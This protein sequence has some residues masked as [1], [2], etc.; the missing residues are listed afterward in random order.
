[1]FG[2]DVEHDSE[3]IMQDTHWASGYFGYFPSYA[4]GNI[5]NA[6]QF[7][8]LKKA[9]P[10]YK[11]VIRSGDLSPIRAWLK[12]QIHA[13]SNLMDPAD[14]MKNIT[15]GKLDATYFVNYLK[16]KCKKV[17]RF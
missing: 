10:N 4:L 6:H 15:G 13:K 8:I 14:L 2:I 16:E 5:Y 3:G 7:E 11:D 1:M 12:E 9:V 17:Y